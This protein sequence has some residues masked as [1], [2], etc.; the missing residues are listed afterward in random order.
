[1][2]RISKWVCGWVG[3]PW[4]QPR[5]D[6]SGYLCGWVREQWIHVRLDAGGCVHGWE[7]NGCESDWLQVGVWMCGATMDASLTYTHP[8]LPTS[9]P[10]PSRFLP[11]TS[12]PTHPHQPQLFSCSPSHV[13]M[14]LL[15]CH[16][17]QVFRC[18]HFRS[19]GLWLT[20]CRQADQ[21][22]LWHEADPN[23]FTRCW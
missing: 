14:Y 9:S 22:S 15:A 4:M 7:N 5:L 19:H 3:E 17:R 8:Y 1:M 12:P 2:G 11:N 18:S 21:N 16:R 13:R 6:A 10:Q 23:L 20:L